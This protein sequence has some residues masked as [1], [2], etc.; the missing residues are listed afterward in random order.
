MPRLNG[1]GPMGQGPMTGW[2]MGRCTNYGAGLNKSAAPEK[3]EIDKDLPEEF[4][5]RGRGFGRGF[6]M[7]WGRGHCFGR[8]RGGYG[9]GRQNG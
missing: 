9:M 8:G 2:K 4:F 6:G 3:E 1:K 7:G 5:G